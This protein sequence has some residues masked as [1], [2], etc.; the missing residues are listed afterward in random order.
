[1]RFLVCY[2]ERSEASR[3]RL[4]QTE[5]LVEKQIEHQVEKMTDVPTSI[6]LPYQRRWIADRSPVKVCE[7][8][9]RIG[10]TWA[11]AADAALDAA[12][13]NGTDWWYIGYNKD[14]AREFIEDAAGW[15]R[16]FDKAARA[17][18][19]VAIE[20]EDKDILAFR[21]RFASGNKIVAL[22]SRPSNLRGKQGVAVI[23]E[24]AF[25][26][27]LPSLIKA[28]L[29]FTMWGGRVHVIS[30]HFGAGNAFNE[31]ISDIR[32]GRRPYSLHRITI[33]DALDD[34]LFAVIK[35]AHNH[36]PDTS[37]A[38]RSEQASLRAALDWDDKTAAQWRAELFAEYADDAD[39]ELMCIPSASSGVFIPSALIEARMSREIPV[40]RWN[41]DLSFMERGEP[42]LRKDAEDWIND[43]LKPVLD[44]IKPE[45][46]SYFG[47]DFGRSGDLTVIW[48][49][50]VSSGLMRRT[51]F[52]IEL[53]N[54]PF[55][56]QKQVLFYLVD[57]LADRSRRFVG[58]AMDARGNGQYLAEQAALR[59][60]SR[61][62]Q[63]MLSSE[64]YRDNMPRYKAAF[65]DGTIDLPGDAD[66][67]ADHRMLR[68]E[69]GIAKIPE[70][71]M[72]GGDGHQRHGDSAIAGA[73]AYYATKS[74]QQ[75]Y[76]YTRAASAAKR[77]E[78]TIPPAAHDEPEDNGVD[79]RRGGWMIQRLGLRRSGAW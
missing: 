69:Q 42:A 58:G 66:I 5:Y 47:E 9:R 17:I 79:S 20:D 25:H 67:L 39:E 11:E 18:E 52:V 61:I 34:G 38:K 50:Q 75:E 29:A 73:L 44:R 49:V 4:Q 72:R 6:L 45:L 48:P 56:Q 70:R 28:A 43:Y 15:A 31:L 40:I 64:W 24:A 53:R 23:D 76:T 54:V 14:M 32:A 16:R 27:H 12:G 57:A 78:H 46:M 8:S 36:K 60:G 55:N 59:Y 77:S 22:S 74:D 7:K 37:R 62:E 3:A 2:A 33:D 30:T 63:V 19:E 10:I 1:V 65:E 21:I 71:R 26:E 51:P 13:R 68:M 41:F 35:R